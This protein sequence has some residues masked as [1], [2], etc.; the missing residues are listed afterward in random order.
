MATRPSIPSK[1][2]SGRGELSVRVL[3]LL[4]GPH[5]MAAATLD[6]PR[7]RGAEEGV[8][9]AVRAPPERR[10][11]RQ[12]RVGHREVNAAAPLAARRGWSRPSSP[13]TQARIAGPPPNLGF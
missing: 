12:I 3:Q 4:D 5:L 9:A 1:C 7:A 8:V 10:T 2:T 11:G 13:Q 6:V